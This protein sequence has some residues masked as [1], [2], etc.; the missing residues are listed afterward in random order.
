MLCLHRAQFPWLPPTSQNDAD[1]TERCPVPWVSSTFVTLLLSVCYHEPWPSDGTALCVR[2][3]LGEDGLAPVL[4]SGQA[5]E[6][7][8]PEWVCMGGRD[9]DWRW[10]RWWGSA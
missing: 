5:C 3:G 7:G 4:A 2:S 9:R 6:G 8:A 1:E 10:E